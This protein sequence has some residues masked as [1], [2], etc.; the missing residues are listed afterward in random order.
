M[1]RN[2]KQSNLHQGS[3]E[4]SFSGKGMTLTHYL[5]YITQ[6]EST[7]GSPAYGWLAELGPCLV[8]CK[9]NNFLGNCAEL[10]KCSVPSA[11]I[12]EQIVTLVSIKL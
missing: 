4:S 6:K 8:I 3:K 9:K 2:K 1:H 11:G 10:D 12:W 5:F 7:S